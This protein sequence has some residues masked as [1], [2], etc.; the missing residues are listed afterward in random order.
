MS[1]IEQ[2]KEA[3][4]SENATFTVKT[5]G[6]GSL[7]I[8]FDDTRLATRTVYN[9]KGEIVSSNQA[10]ASEVRKNFLA[11]FGDS[12]EFDDESITDMIDA[13]TGNEL[14]P[15]RPIGKNLGSK[16]TQPKFDA[17]VGA[18]VNQQSNLRDKTPEEIQGR[19]DSESESFAREQERLQTAE[20]TRRNQADV[21]RTFDAR[22]KNDLKNHPR[23]VEQRNKIKKR[24]KRLKNLD[25]PEASNLV[26]TIE[27][28]DDEIE[29]IE[30]RGFVQ[31]GES[32][33]EAK[34]RTGKLPDFKKNRAYSSGGVSKEVNFPPDTKIFKSGSLPQPAV[35]QSP[36]KSFED[37]QTRRSSPVTASVLRAAGE[38]GTL[39]RVAES[40]QRS[41]RGPG[42]FLS[43]D[44]L[45]AMDESPTRDKALRLN[46]IIKR[47]EDG[48]GTKNRDARIAKLQAELDI[49][50]MELRNE[51][52]IRPTDIA[53]GFDT[54]KATPVMADPEGTIPQ[55]D[56]SEFRTRGPLTASQTQKVQTARAKATAADREAD[57][58]LGQGPSPR[59]RLASNLKTKIED[60]RTKI[61]SLGNPDGESMESMRL[62]KSYQEEAFRLEGRLGLITGNKTDARTAGA[63]DAT[64]STNRGQERAS[65]QELERLER[66]PL[67]RGG[68]GFR[69]VNI[70]SGQTDASDAGS[71][72]ADR[73]LRDKMEAADQEIRNREAK[74]T[75]EY[76]M[77]DY[78]PAS[79]ELLGPEPAPKPQAT[80][81]R[82]ILARK[83]VDKMEANDAERARKS[84]ELPELEEELKQRVFAEGKRGKGDKP[85]FRDDDKT[86][87]ILRRLYE[88]KRAEVG[89]KGATQYMAQL[90]KRMG[91]TGRSA[92][93]LLLSAL[94]LAGLAVAGSSSGSGDRR[95]A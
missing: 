24:F 92:P 19:I 20:R 62:R 56:V 28:L 45:I 59:E 72:R 84:G 88:G 41:E 3:L 42:R 69:E 11:K 47:I 80:S 1:S 5:D 76:R 66:R 58:V 10:P 94:G 75:R 6:G 93:L 73:L 40:V 46:E 36:L 78:D 39:D 31:V 60:L 50:D 25:S 38:A 55:R 74:A 33:K 91:M 17:D 9:S 12:I 54:D 2:I 22:A 18:K 26:A 43:V 8:Q 65:Q 57:R 68:K 63:G 82:T 35:R 14:K 49:V 61:A 85:L 21:E 7:V 34:K 48:P 67:M 77:R 23:L 53:Q 27:K 4:N 79:D 89:A 70:R 86:K 15:P 44:E 87:G 81:R 16:R 32:R 83:A 51:P 13:R 71:I 52:N 29:K 95:A 64:T 37:L 30:A 90:F